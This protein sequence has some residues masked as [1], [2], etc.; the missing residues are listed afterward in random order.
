MW[1]GAFLV[2]SSRTSLNR[3]GSAK[4]VWQPFRYVTQFAVHDTFAFL[5]TGNRKEGSV[6]FLRFKFVIGNGI[7]QD[8]EH[9]QRPLSLTITRYTIELELYHTQAPT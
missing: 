9:F 5:N 3:L 4:N 7:F 6:S 8:Q 1:C 2:S